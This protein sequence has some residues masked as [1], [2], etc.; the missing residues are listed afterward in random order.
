MAGGMVA[1]NAGGARAVKVC[2]L[3]RGQ[4]PGTPAHLRA[5]SRRK[6]SHELHAQTTRGWSAGGGDPRLARQA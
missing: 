5:R 2:S 6:C 4:V 1:T 3:F